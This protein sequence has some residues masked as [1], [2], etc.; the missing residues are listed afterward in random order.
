MDATK[1]SLHLNIAQCWLKITDATNHLEQAIRS[2]TDALE[3]DAENIKAS[4]RAL[5]P[6]YRD[7]YSYVCGDRDGRGTAAAHASL[8]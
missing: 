6:G 7:S 1:L 3:I 5:A 2:C 8:V 4:A